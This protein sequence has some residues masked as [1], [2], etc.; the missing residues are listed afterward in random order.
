MNK[1]KLAP[2]GWVVAAL[3]AGFV[4]AG[5]FQGAQDK[6]GVVDLNK[7]VQNSEMGKK[8]HEELDAM[9]TAR[10]GVIEFMQQHRV[11]TR[12]QANKLKTLS[13]KTSL[14]DAESKDL[15]K[16]K[17]DVK[18][19]HTNFD[20][21]NQKSNPTEDERNLLQQY[22]AFIQATNELVQDWGGQFSNE[23]EQRQNQMI[24][25][26]VQKADNAIKEVS[27]K[28]GYTVVFS[29]P[30]AAV[31]GANDLTDAVTKALNAQKS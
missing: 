19:S 13:L 31:Y 15:N 29:E 12:E 26:S 11:L 22:N 18:A 14:S 8:N 23:L 30:A 3:M 17:E 6:I 24:Q 7:A 25:D 4:F 21:L 27:K 2:L 20:V 9:V 1:E 28:E 16:V 10:K 5:G